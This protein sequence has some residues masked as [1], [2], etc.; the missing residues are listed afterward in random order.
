MNRIGRVWRRRLAG[1]LLGAALATPV[2]V[3][4]PDPA[5]A[6]AMVRNVTERMLDV[7]R[8]EP[9]A[10]AESEK[11]W[12]AE[13]ARE[14]VAPSLDFVTMTKL[15]VGRAWLDAGTEQKRALV[16]Q[17][18][19]L[20]LN[21]YSQSL[22]EYD[23]EQIEFLPLRAGGKPGRATVRA[24]VLQGGGPE[25]IV[26]FSA[27]YNDGE[28][29]VYDITV[30]GVS[31]VTNYRSTFSSVIREEGIDGLVETLR[32]KNADNAGMT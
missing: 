25:I 15:A 16:T 26:V 7:L 3:A 8:S 19:E 4:A 18:R 29:S 20:L 24:K 6:Q 22:N 11:A 23:N 9:P 5:D 28:W 21:T 13:Q 2:A 10:S 1:L 12:L 31:L 32:E 17:F 14:I 30:D 27:R